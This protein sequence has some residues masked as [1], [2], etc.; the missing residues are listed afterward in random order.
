VKIV[1]IIG[2][3]PQFV[4]AAV[5]SRALRGY[6]GV[7]DVLV[8]TGQHFDA[9]MSQ[10]FFEELNLPE[11]D[12]YLGI[13]GGSHGQQTGRMLEQV[14]RVIQR[15]HP[16]WVLV[17]GDTNSTLAGA[18]AAVKLHVPVAHVEAGL[19]SF[20]RRMPEEINRIVTD[21]VSE[22]LFAPTDTAVAHLRRE[23]IPEEKIQQVGDVMFDAARLFQDR[24]SQKRALL[25]RLAV[26]A[27]GYVLATIHRAE[28]TDDPNR[29]TA[30]FDGLAAVARGKMPVVLPLHPRTRQALASAGTLASYQQAL[31]LIPPVGFLEM[32]V[33]EQNAALIATDSGGVQKE[34]YFHQVPCVTL[35]DETEWVELV[36]TG[37]NQIV[38]PHDAKRVQQG[39]LAGLDRGRGSPVDLYGGGQ[40]SARIAGGLLG[41]GAGEAS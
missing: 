7:D 27:G 36:A 1:S 40:A 5:V 14:E 11:P 25:D 39:I 12:H 41:V 33:L 17:Y 10:I 18:L 19:R 21:H 20:N 13:Q 30:I 34:A 9:N 16:H 24:A 3:R 4:K 37:W 38:P 8:H 22:R 26:T 35:R 2:A 28:N 23:G 6:P 15:E 31:H 29:L 32:I